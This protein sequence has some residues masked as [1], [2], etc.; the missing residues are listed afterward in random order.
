MDKF[1]RKLE[2]LDGLETDYLRVLYYDLN[3]NYQSTYKSYEYKRLC[4]IISGEK[5]VKINN[6]DVITYDPSKYMLLPSNSSVEMNIKEPTKAIALEL[7]EDLINGVSQKL[8]FNFDISSKS[9]NLETPFINSKNNLI[10]VSIKRII[11]T[12]NSTI[13]HKEFLLDLYAQEIVYD[14]LNTKI[15]NTILTNNF[16]DPISNSIKIMK[17]N[18][19]NNITISEIAYSVNIPLSMF[20]LEFK[21]VIGISPNKYLT[22]L[23]LNES[24]NL[25]KTHSVT[26]V[27]FDL[28]YENISH[29]IAL[30]KN[31][32]GVTPKQYTLK[33]MNNSLLKT[34]RD[35]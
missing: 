7:N 26:D 31:K 13:T 8:N 10:D 28:G 11:E 2:L 33:Y 4:L 29:F 1:D 14:L 15:A 24:L 18:F 22:N 35:C 16:N 5:T 12:A 21:K 17:A 19:K 3:K 20:S 34:S 27:A 32:F 6:G 25:L 9:L 23:K 30:F